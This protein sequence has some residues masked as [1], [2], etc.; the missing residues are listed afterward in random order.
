MIDSRTREIAPGVEAERVATEGH[1][2]YDPATGS[3]NIIF[4]GEEFL[5]LGGELGA[6]LDGRQALMLQL[7]E[8]DAETFNAGADPVSGLDLSRVSLAGLANVVRALY[9]KK[10]ADAYRVP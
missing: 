5:K 9:A 6:K 10:H 2:F 1:F 8:E 3:A 7:S 4:Q